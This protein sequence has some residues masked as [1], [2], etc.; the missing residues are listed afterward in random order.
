MDRASHA[1]LG[2]A[3]STGPGLRMVLPVRG[4]TCASCV[5]HVEKAL[6]RVPGVQKVAVNLATESAAVEGVGLDAAALTGAVSA[7]GYEVPGQHLRLAVQA[8][9]C[10]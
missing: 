8:M 4:M 2:G 6:A 1:S 10:A 9:T 7:A 5:A 3:P